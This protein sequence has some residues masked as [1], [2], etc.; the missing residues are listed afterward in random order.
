M[1]KN[2]VKKE[3]ECNTLCAFLQHQKI[4]SERKQHYGRPV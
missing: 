1:N 3:G 2:I 4:P